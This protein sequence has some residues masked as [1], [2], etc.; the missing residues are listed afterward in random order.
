LAVID[1]SPFER[2]EIATA[3]PQVRVFPESG[4][5]ALLERP[6]FDLPVSEESRQRRLSYLAEGRRKAIDYAEFLKS[7]EMAA[8][9]FRP[10][11]DAS[12]QRCL[13]L[14]QRSNQLNLEPLL[15]QG[16]VPR[17]ARRFGHLRDRPVVQGPLR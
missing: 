4:L 5:L 7:C 3:L 15:R 9:L 8:H 12:V 16:R 2:D 17:A 10:V 14:I 1:D 6:E 13:E 11:T